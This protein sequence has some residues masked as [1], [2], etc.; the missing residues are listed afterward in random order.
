LLKHKLED[1]VYKQATLETPKQII[2]V[3]IPVT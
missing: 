2:Y 1:T 3:V